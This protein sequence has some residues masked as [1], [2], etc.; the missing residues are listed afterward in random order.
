[1]FCTAV[2][3]KCNLNFNL[4]T[5]DFER[6]LFPTSTLLATNTATQPP[7][8]QQKLQQQ[9]QLGQLP[10][11]L[12]EAIETSTRILETRTA[13]THISTSSSTA[14]FEGTTS[15][16]NAKR[17]SDGR[18]FSINARKA[19]NNAR[20][21]STTTTS[22][23]ALTTQRHH[24]S[25]QS[26]S[27]VQSRKKKRHLLSSSSFEQRIPGGHSKKKGKTMTDT[28]RFTSIK[29]EDRQLHHN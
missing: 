13:T 14:H 9:Q 24:S 7:P 29:K 6:I 15:I 21:A 16:H 25:S 1:M 12:T 18:N 11:D 8:P 19:K 10:W 17:S 22:K 5:S 27:A 26:S 4:Q 20:L 2:Y 23:N 28:I 3:S